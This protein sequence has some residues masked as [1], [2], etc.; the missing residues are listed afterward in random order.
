MEAVGTFIKDQTPSDYLKLQY[1]SRKP[2]FE[3]DCLLPQGHHYA[4]IVD[5]IISNSSSL[6]LSGSTTLSKVSPRDPSLSHDIHGRFNFQSLSL[7]YRKIHKQIR[8]L[9]GNQVNFSSLKITLGFTCLCSFCVHN[10]R[11][12]DVDTFI[13]GLEP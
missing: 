5:D 4:A 7:N 13:L 8:E 6:S 2:D 1:F 9:T 12:V 10:D 3:D 11:D